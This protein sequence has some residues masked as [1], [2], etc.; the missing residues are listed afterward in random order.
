MLVANLVEGNDGRWSA[1]AH[2]EIYRSAKTAGE[3]FQAV[4]R[5]EL[6]ASLCVNWVRGRH[7]Q[8]IVGLPSQLLEVFSKRRA[9]IESWLSTNGRADTPH[10]AQEATLATRRGKPG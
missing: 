8:E 6:T 9:E 1:F 7:V 2:P 5:R 3:I 10:A 4:A